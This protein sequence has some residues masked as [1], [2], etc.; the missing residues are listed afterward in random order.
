MFLL[1]I[2]T[3]HL[4]RWCC[5]K[6]SPWY[7]GGKRAVTFL[8]SVQDKEEKS[9]DTGETERSEKRLLSENRNRRP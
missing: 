7:T 9:E 1:Y 6:R 4:L 8:E 3:S 5:N 2:W